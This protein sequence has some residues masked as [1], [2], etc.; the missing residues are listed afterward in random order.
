MSLEEQ[1][2]RMVVV[3]AGA[4]G[5]EFAYFYHTIAAFAGLSGNACSTQSQPS[6]AAGSDQGE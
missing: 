6:K 2:K 1:P 3:G 4:I 5:V